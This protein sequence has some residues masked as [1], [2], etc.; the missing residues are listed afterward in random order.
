[1][2]V[3][4]FIISIAGA[5]WGVLAWLDYLLSVM[6]THEASA[7][8]ISQVANQATVHLLAGI[9]LIVLGGLLVCAGY[10]GDVRDLQK[11]AAGPSK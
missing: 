6:G 10:F 4:G 2:K 3:L 8:Q 11:K 9:G 5:L 1:M 7:M